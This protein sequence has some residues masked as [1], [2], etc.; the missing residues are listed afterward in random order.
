MNK[1]FINIA[2]YRDPELI[3]TVRDAIEK[4]QNKERLSI[5]ICWQFDKDEP[6]NFDEEKDPI[7]EGVKLR[8]IRIPQDKSMGMNWARKLAHGFWSKE[9]NYYLQI[10]SHMR[11]VE[12]WDYELVKLIPQCDSDNPI[13]SQRCLP[14]YPKTGEVKPIGGTTFL[15]GKKFR[16]NGVLT[17]AAGHI[18]TKKEG[19]NKPLATAFIS[20]HFMFSRAGLIKQMPYDEDIAI[21][22]TGDEPILSIKSFTRG[23]DIFAPHKP[24]LYHHFYRD[25]HPKFHGDHKDKN[26]KNH[27]DKLSKIGV[28]RTNQILYENYVGEYGLGTERSLKD[29][30]EYAHIDFEKREVKTPSLRIKKVFKKK[31]DK[32]VTTMTDA[33]LDPKDKIY[34]QIASYR[35]PD[36][37]FTIKDMLS[38]AKK[39]E[40]LIVGVCDQ[41]GPENKHL[42]VYDKENFRV[43]RMPFYSSKGLGWA[44]A[45]LQTLYFDDAEYT[46]QLDSHMR[47]VQDWDSKL[48]KMVKD[49]GSE[50]P[51]ISHYCPGFT[52]KDL[53]GETYLDKQG[54]L[55]M[56]CLRFNDTGTVSFRSNHVEKEN[57]TGKPIPSILVSGHFYF[58]LAKHIREYKYDPELYFAGDEVS[59]A[60]RSWTRGWDIFNPSESVVY[61][62]YSREK[63]ICHWADQK[64]GY[65]S[66]HEES[67][68]KLRQMLHGEKNRIKIGEYGLGQ[69]RKLRDFEKISGIDFKNR[70]LADHALS[71]HPKF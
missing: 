17:V 68:K 41:Y 59:L 45:M 71:G 30:G 34:V 25:D 33:N 27:W 58:T 70:E 60:T 15:H 13:I 43:I 50:K 61:H 21:I 55:K 8:Y 4:A 23:W 11:F 1:I 9:Y 39:P 42:P 24:V 51:I 36:V 46:M 3:P 14:Y 52:S 69:E 19:I 67:L 47:F 48:I 29:F 10:D 64:V 18:N 32:H 26:K 35:D 66:L 44:R 2:A 5:G 63:R 37:E 40:N 49:S 38:K 7:F 12:N 31:K 28:K 6:E 20:G 54:L 53:E 57:K 22:A 65:G 62:N 16:D 56:Y